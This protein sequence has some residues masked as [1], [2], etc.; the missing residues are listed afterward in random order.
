MAFEEF[1][2]AC[3]ESLLSFVGED[4]QPDMPRY[5]KE[6]DNAHA[7]SGDISTAAELLWLPY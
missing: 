2:Q 4:R 1:E 3:P 7:F 5:V 6:K